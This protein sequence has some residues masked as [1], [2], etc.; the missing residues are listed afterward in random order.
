MGERKIRIYISLAD[1]ELGERVYHSSQERSHER[2]WKLGNSGQATKVKVQ[3]SIFSASSSLPVILVQQTTTTTMTA[4]G[5]R[6]T[7]TKPMHHL[8]IHLGE[9]WRT[10]GCRFFC[11]RREIAGNEFILQ[12]KSALVENKNFS[13]FASNWR[14]I[15]GF[16]QSG[17]EELIQK[18]S[19]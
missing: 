8:V 16:P 5:N 3:L 2:K 12:I 19:I 4:S 18:L 17:V 10:R 1:H 14:S 15:G 9:C 13:T 11:S 7:P 6:Q